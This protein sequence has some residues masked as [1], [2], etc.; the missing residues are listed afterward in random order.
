MDAVQ[1][2]VFFKCEK[3]RHPKRLVFH[4]CLKNLSPYINVAV[5][6]KADKCDNN[7]TDPIT[8]T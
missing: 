8:V 5:C 1:T 4:H 7:K 3:T 2:C 6:L